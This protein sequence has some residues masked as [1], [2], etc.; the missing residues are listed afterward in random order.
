MPPVACSGYGEGVGRSRHSFGVGLM[1]VTLGCAEP[2]GRPPG[3]DGGWDSTSDADSTADSGDADDS[4]PGV[5]VGSLDDLPDGDSGDGDGDGDGDGE[6]PYAAPLYPGDW[7]HSPISPFIRDNLASIRALAPAAPA[8]LFIKV[9]ASSTVNPNT[10]FCF[11]DPAKVELDA[12]ADALAPSL[13][14][15]RA[16]VAG[17]TT[18]FDRVTLAAEVGRTASWAITGDPS[19]VAAS[20]ALVHYG[21][22]DMQMGLTYASALPGYHANMSDLLDLLIDQGVVPVVFGLSRRL[23]QDGADDWV[24]TYNAVARGLAQD[25][26]VPFVDLRLALEGLPGYGL[27]G[28]GLHLEADPE[29]ACLLTPAGLGHGYNV[30]NLVALEALARLRAALVDEQPASEPPPPLLLGHGSVDDPLRIPALPF[31]DTRTTVDAPGLELDVYTGCMAA[32]D[33]S[34]PEWVYR[35]ELTEPTALRA[36]VLDRAGVD[37]DIH[38]LDEH[39]DEAGCLARDDTRIERALDPGTYHFALDTYVDGQGD[40]LAGEYTFVVLACEPGDPDCL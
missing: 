19:P 14:F 9:G 38:L 32:A 17:E 3:I 15:Y 28:D 20:L 34:G 1:A 2:A 30:R 21:A 25:R 36:V 13:E 27:S 29:G 23:D 37:V 26:G 11:A 33:E 24:P 39:A 7:V 12:L 5:D 10:L 22:N 40:E 4:G 16:G 31:A 8:P 18:P 6:P 35:I